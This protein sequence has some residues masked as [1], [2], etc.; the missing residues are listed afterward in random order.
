LKILLA[1]GMHEL[2]AHGWNRTYFVAEEEILCWVDQC[3]E[4]PQCLED[5]LCLDKA[6]AIKD[7]LQEYAQKHKLEEKSQNQNE[8]NQ[9]LV[10]RSS[11]LVQSKLR[12][13]SR[14]KIPKMDKS[15]GDDA[16]LNVIPRTG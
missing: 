10:S 8:Q 16:L 14:P 5:V 6:V 15:S 3:R 11:T 13:L 1:A 9:L 7:M 4:T 12:Q 2:D